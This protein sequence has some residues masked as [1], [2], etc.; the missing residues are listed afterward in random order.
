[1]AD[2]NNTGTTTPMPQTSFEPAAPLGGDTGTVNFEPASSPGST[3]TDT[4][5][6]TKDTIKAEAGKIGTQAADKARA[7]AGDGKAKATG[8]INDLAR[9]MEDAAGQVDEK[10]G[11]Q[12]GDYARS[13]AQSL[14]G[15][16]SQIDQ[17]D[18]DELLEDVRGFVRKSP[19]IAIG[20]AAALGF[21]IAR[22]VKAGVEPTDDTATTGGSTVS[23]ARPPAATGGA[24]TVGGTT[25]T[26]TT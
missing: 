11:S 10:L 26:M 25:T 22:V 1:M 4:S 16:A 18:I 17:K 19:A 9:M 21:V 2:Q 13:A 24:T 23:T 7:F 6:S 15:F 12:Y 3:S 8:A 5:R 14:G 20:T